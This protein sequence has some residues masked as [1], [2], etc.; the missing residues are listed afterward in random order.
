MYAD[1]VSKL[2]FRHLQSL[3]RA[4]VNREVVL[5]RAPAESDFIFLGFGMEM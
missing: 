4:V 5:L 3:P 2:L 1:G